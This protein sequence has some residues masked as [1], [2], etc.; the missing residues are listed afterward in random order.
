MKENILKTD[1]VQG[2]TI[3]TLKK[4]SKVE[5]ITSNILAVLAFIA[6]GFIA[7][8][9]IIQTC[10]FDPANYN[11]EVILFN[12]DLI[13]INIVVFLLFGVIVYKA[14][15][16]YDFFA[17]VN[18]KFMYG[19]M[20][21]YVLALGLLWIFSVWQIPGADSANIFETATEV[22]KGDYSSLH[23]G[24][25]SY[26]SSYYNEISYYNFYPFQLGFV[27]ICEI[28]YRIFGTETSMPVQV[29]NVICTAL[30]YCG[31]ARI[32]KAVFKKKSIEFFSIIL[33]LTCIQ[34]IL[35]CSF[36]YGNIIGMCF[37][38]W[39]S[40]FLI[41]YMQ[42]VNYLLLIPCT[43]LLTI[44]VLAK[45]NNLIYV[46]AFAIV[47][48][49]HTISKRKI[50]SVAFAL[51][52]CIITVSANNL[53]IMSYE[54]R[55]DVDLKD[56]V[57]QIMYLGM[58][59]N[60]SYMAPGW[61]SGKFMG[62][63]RDFNCD[64]ELTTYKVQED[65]SS[66]LN[67]F[68][69]DP[70][71]AVEF[72]TNKIISQWHEPTYES[73][74]VSKSKSHLKEIPAYVESIYNGNTGQVLDVYFNQYTQIVFLFFAIGLIYLLVRKKANAETI[75]LPLVLLGA[76]GYHLLFEAKSQYALTY[77]ILLIPTASFGI[78]ALIIDNADKFKQFIS[79]LKTLHTTKG[80]AE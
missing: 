30:A 22:I 69:E 73:I 66:S 45:Y 52:L 40:Y 63:Y 76:F 9:S 34:P 39:A 43:I 15:K 41:R 1:T 78:K 47:L 20:F 42:S 17:K 51:L 13:P 60:E 54:N 24:G 6:F 49:I 36:P 28:I 8:M 68:S 27:F 31:I 58:G 26:F 19:G 2:T 4:R 74:W 72:F 14:N 46:V 44:A 53:V 3:N 35:F 71:F 80:P 25:E 37:S 67:K 10:V 29:I 75:L 32:T 38:I 64:S 16:S 5:T 59:L 33:L 21:V 55:A 62:Y 18:M 65:I 7:V 57:P 77:I 79:K 12:F 23:D 56:G 48:L 50:Q 11:S 70:G 61:Y